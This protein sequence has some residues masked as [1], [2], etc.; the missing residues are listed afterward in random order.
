MDKSSKKTTKVKDQGF[1]QRPQVQALINWLIS[2]FAIGVLITALFMVFAQIFYDVRSQNEEGRRFSG[3]TG[4]IFQIVQ[5][6]DFILTDA[7]FLTRGVIPQPESK[8]AL[9]AIDDESVRMLGRWPWSRDLMAEILDQSFKNGAR[10][11][12]LDVVWSEPQDNPELQTLIEIESSIKP[13]PPALRQFISEKRAQKTPDQKL[14]DVIETNKDKIVLGV[15][16]TDEN[17]KELKP[18]TDYCRNE[19]FN[20]VN[21]NT[22]VKID[23]FTFLV[24]DKADR[25]ETL[26][27]NDVFDGIFQ[28]IRN[29]TIIQMMRDRFQKDDPEKLTAVEKNQIMAEI[30][31]HYMHYCNQ[32]LTPPS[33]DPGSASKDTLSDWATFIKFFG[34]LTSSDPEEQKVSATAEIKDFVGLS[35]ED[36][37]NKFKTSVLSH[38]V[39]QY[40]SW[41]INLPEF[42]DVAIY[43]GA[44][45]ADQDDDGKIRRNPLFYRTGNR[46]GGS[47]IPSIALQT[48]LAGNPGYQAVVE[49]DV[50][51]H[52]HQKVIKSFK[53][54]DI[55]K[56]EKDQFVAQI[57]VDNQGRLKIN[58]AGPG[59][60]YPYIPA[61]ELASNLDTMK[62][63]QRVTD[64][65]TGQT[66]ILERTVN[67]KEYL[68]GK[69]L[70]LGA[71]AI[72]VY[73]LRVTP[74]DKNYPGP[75]THL[76]V[77]DNL[78][79]HNFIQ[80]HPDEQTAMMWALGL[81]GIVLSAAVAVAGPFL[82]FF[83]MLI[84]VGSLTWIDQLLLRQGYISTSVLPA[85]LFLS[86]YVLMTL[87]KY[88]TEERKK[89]HLRST[90][91]KYVS[92]AIVDE[93]LKSPENVELGGHKQRMSVFFSD[94]R[95]FTAFSE[96]L[97]P[98][99]LSDVLNRYLTP[100]TQIVF[101]NKGTLDKYMG[102]A[103][104][105][106][107]GAPIAYGD[108]ATHAC[109]CALESLRRLKTLQAEFAAEGLPHIDIGIG[110]NTAEVSVGN[111][112]SETVRSYTVMG[113]GVN[114]ASRLEGI[115]KEYGTRIIISEFTRSELGESFHVREV[116]W[117]KVKGKAKPVR[118]F[119]L[120]GEGALP[121]DQAEAIKHFCT[122]FEK[123]HAMQFELAKFD[124][125]CALRIIPDD[126]P[127]KLYVERCEDFIQNPPGADWD[128]VYTMKTK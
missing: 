122:G 117:V 71:T 59:M 126:E 52:N 83:V 7:R 14:K 101:E 21:G 27:F 46:V 100:M 110:I 104:M 62:V 111:M 19:A 30:E 69:F 51:A 107:F 40:E 2:P 35:A 118:I 84:G 78:I 98:Q 44:F 97:E 66:G 116:D 55:N 109:R 67:K 3:I 125:E 10:A 128:G 120:V 121:N 92:P 94:V 79:N 115:N 63:R 54:I 1:L 99:V 61:K 17:R 85:L 42:H 48:Y 102:D 105:A 20:R 89:K 12:G 53:I 45:A 37:I 11:V 74:F 91:S 96:R 41:T 76:T 31:R 112:G 80:T 13:P 72:G 6:L 127:A 15:F 88:F 33:D 58:Y 43:S 82:G 26:K 29:T 70:I 108:H 23:N 39:P 93:I 60:T 22:F 113:D 87:Y 50:D 34:H 38:P 64:P 8:V 68:D 56:D 25:F 4:G 9:I 119:E 103:V 95:G 124:F 5:G 65:K 106:F 16:P 18:F 73:D 24:E 36:A 57:P 49:I 123:Y 90:F 81:L 32:W 75:E 86:I 28:A 77:L 47:F 114:L